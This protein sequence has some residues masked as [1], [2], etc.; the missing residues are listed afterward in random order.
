MQ[1]MSYKRTSRSFKKKRGENI[2]HNDLELGKEFLNR[3]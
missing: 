3:K 1:C 2:N